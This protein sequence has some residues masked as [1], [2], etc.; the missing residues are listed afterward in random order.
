MQDSW[1]LTNLS[2]SSPIQPSLDPLLAQQVKRAPLVSSMSN[3]RRAVPFW[4]SLKLF[5]VHA[6]EIPLTHLHCTL[7]V[8]IQAFFQQLTILDRSNTLRPEN[9][10]SLL[11]SLRKRMSYESCVI[12]TGPSRIEATRDCASPPS[13]G[14]DLPPTDG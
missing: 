3:A 9:R 14:S 4:P 11:N 13:R 10:C 8:S 7:V 12:T 2:N 5:P 1:Y 6:L